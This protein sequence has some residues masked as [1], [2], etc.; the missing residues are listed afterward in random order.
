MITGFVLCMLG[1]VLTIWGVAH[2]VC[3]NDTYELHRYQERK[4]LDCAHRKLGRIGLPKPLLIYT[5]DVLMLTG[6]T[7]ET[8]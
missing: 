1:L 8:T 7:D 5:E 4:E 2:T 3:K 6:R